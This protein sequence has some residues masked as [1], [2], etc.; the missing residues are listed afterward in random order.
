ML[1][2]MIFVLLGYVTVYD[3]SG[4]AIDL[5]EVDNTTCVFQIHKL[6]EYSHVQ[7]EWDGRKLPRFCKMSFIGRSAVDVLNRYQMCVE[8]L[9]YDIDTCDFA[10]K[11]YSGFNME[12][13][14]EY[15]CYSGLPPKFCADEETYLDIEFEAGSPSTSSLTLT[16]TATLTYHY[17]GNRKHI[18]TD[19]GDMAVVYIGV[20]IAIISGIVIGCVVLYLIY[21][22]R[23]QRSNPGVIMQPATSNIQNHAVITSGQLNQPYIHTGQ[24]AYQPQP[25]AMV[26]QHSTPIAP[27]MYSETSTDTSKPPPFH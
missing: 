17:D 15:S 19:T 4:T 14:R 22:Y 8:V 5:M 16:L 13:S 7:V 10:M 1:L 25:A 6:N 18:L 27:P 23:N 26:V 9:E 24:G 21:R 12:P 11:F 2:L 3:V 20:G